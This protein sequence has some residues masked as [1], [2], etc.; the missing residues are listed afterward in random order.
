MK[1]LFL[2]PFAAVLL[3]SVMSGRSQTNGPGVDFKNE[4]S[5]A[6]ELTAKKSNPGWDLGADAGRIAAM[7]PAE[8]A[9]EKVLEENLGSFYLPHY[10]RDKLAG[11]ETAWDYVKDDPK[12]PRVLLIGDSIS[13]GY[14]LAVRHNL[15]GKA[16]VHRA[17]ANCG[18]TAYG[19]EKLP[20]WLGDGK[21]NVIH[22]NFGIHDRGTPSPVYAE[23]LE[24]IIAELKKTGAKLVWARSTPPAGV[25][26]TE[27]YSEAQCEKLNSVADGVMQRHGIPENDLYTLIKPRLAELQLPNNVHFREE[28]YEVLGRQVA[29]SILAALADTKN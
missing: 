18:R 27:K 29:D 4:P 1:V 7:S 14:T 5:N 20:V 28:G 23:N 3:G 10:K 2:I 13:R 6:A 9:W 12:L 21:W 19:L 8:R 25:E 15:Q 16:N 24:K 11:K 17:P 26:N 22:F